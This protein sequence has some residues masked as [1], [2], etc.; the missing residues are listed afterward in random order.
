[1]TCDSNWISS[2]RAF[3]PRTNGPKDILSHSLPLLRGLRIPC[4]FVDPALSTSTVCTVN[5]VYVPEAL[6]WKL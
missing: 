2:R 4:F 3:Q 1:M 5:D 6:T